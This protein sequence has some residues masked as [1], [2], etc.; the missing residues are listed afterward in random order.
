MCAFNHNL[1]PYLVKSSPWITWTSKFHLVKP[2]HSIGMDLSTTLL[3][4]TLQLHGWQTCLEHH[5]SQQS[6]DPSRVEKV[7][8]HHQCS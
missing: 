2:D 6:A 3:A 1:Q 4:H 5:N 7:S 8:L